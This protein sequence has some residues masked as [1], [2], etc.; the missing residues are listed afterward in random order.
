MLS[1]DKDIR[2]AI[3]K[4]IKEVIEIFDNLYANSKERK[5]QFNISNPRCR[6]SIMTIFG[7]LE[8]DRIYYYDKKDKNKHFYFIDT[9]FGFSKYDRYD[10]LVKAIAIS[11]AME[12]NQKKGAEITNDR[13]NSL[14][15][16]I[17]GKKICNVSRQDIYIWIDKWNVPD[18]QLEPIDIDGDTLY[19][20]IDEKYIHEQIKILLGVNTDNDDNV[21]TKNNKEIIKEIADEL[22]NSLNNPLLLLPAPKNKTKKFIMSKAFVAFTGMDVKGSRRTLEN[23]VTFLTSSKQPWQDFMD[24]IPTIF[25]FSKI[26]NIKVLSDA[27][28]WITAGIYNLKLFVENIIIPCIS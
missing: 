13:I 17:S 2:I 25:D 4:I 28:T 9:L 6:R 24:F 11:N 10:K 27:G 7:E 20:M 8:F 12:T 3:L 14:E 15:D 23:K 1:L 21:E 18:V 16:S 22:M 5:K 26:K 19:I